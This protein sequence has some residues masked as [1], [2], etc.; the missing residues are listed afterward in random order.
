VAAAIPRARRP[1]RSAASV[2]APTARKAP[3]LHSTRASLHSA[4]TWRGGGGKEGGGG[5]WGRQGGGWRGVGA[6][7]EGGG[8]RQAEAQQ[9]TGR[10]RSGRGR[11]GPAHLSDGGKSGVEAVGGEALDVALV[12]VVCGACLGRG[13]PRGRE[14]REQGCWDGCSGQ[15]ERGGRGGKEH[16]GGEAAGPRANLEQEEQRAAASRPAPG[17]CPPP[18]TP[19]PAPAPR[20]APATSSSRSAAPPSAPA[21]TS[22][23]TLIWLVVSVPVLS[24]QI[25]VVQPSV[26]TLGSFLRVR[27]SGGVGVGVGVGVGRDRGGGRRQD[28]G[29][30]LEVSGRA[31]GAAR[32]TGSRRWLEKL[33]ARRAPPDDRVLLGHLARAKRE[34]GRDDC[35]EALRDGRDGQGDLCGA[36]GMGRVGWVGGVG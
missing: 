20:R 7:R 26:S 36:W 12:R 25:T 11:G 2:G 16:R 32:A 33:G 23:T 15:R 35:G 9:T 22:V 10:L 17:P 21:V 13:R 34:A 3:P 6:A 31:L 14:E 8:D 19:A 18:A 30:G 5:G 1:T 28:I 29:R 4:Q 24:E 27:G